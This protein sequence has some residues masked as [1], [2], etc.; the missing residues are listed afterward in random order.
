MPQAASAVPRLMAVVVLPTPPFWLAIANTRPI[1][2]ALRLTIRRTANSLKLQE[3]ALDPDR[4]GTISACICQLCRAAVNSCATFS[5]LRNR[6]S[7]GSST[8]SA[9][10]RSRGKGA[11]ARAVTTSPRRPCSASI[12]RR[13]PPPAPGDARRLTQ[14]L[15]LALIALDQMDARATPS[16][17]RTRP[18]SPAPLPDRSPSRPSRAHARRTGR[19]RGYGG[20]RDR[21]GCWRRPG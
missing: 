15:G 14:E 1:C 4:L 8:G 7:A 3:D 5:P 16:S 21:Q 17:A 6:Q 2:G 9:S 12:R 10:P 13:E 11:S 20:A 19:N 18:G